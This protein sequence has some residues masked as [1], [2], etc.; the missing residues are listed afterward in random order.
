MKLSHPIENVLDEVVEEIY[1]AYPSLQ[2][3]YGETGKIKCREDNQHHLDHLLTAYQVGQTKV[4]L[5]YSLWLN[6]VLTT[7]GMKGEHLR[8]NFEKLY[9]AIQDK[10]PIEQQ[11]FYQQCLKKAIYELELS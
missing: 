4:F 7:R 2:E 11:V 5:D 10:L 3:D 9:D 6:N 8:F 1:K